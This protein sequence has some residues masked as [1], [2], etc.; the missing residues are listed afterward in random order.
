MIHDHKNIASIVIRRFSSGVYACVRVSMC[1]QARELLAKV[2]FFY[3]LNAIFRICVG[4]EVFNVRPSSHC[5]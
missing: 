4:A 3:T 2:W 5:S 1:Y